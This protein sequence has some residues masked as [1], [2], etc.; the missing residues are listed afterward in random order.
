MFSN[1]SK[2]RMPVGVG[3]HTPLSIPFAGG[4]AADYVMRVAVG[5]QVELNERNLPTGRKLPLSEQFA[6]LREGGLRVTECDPIEAGFTLKEIDV[7]GKVVPRGAGRERAHGCADLLRG[8]FPDDL[9]DDLEQRGPGALRRRPEPQSWT[10]NALESSPQS[11]RPKG[12][13]RIAP[14]ESW[15]MVFPALREI[16]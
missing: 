6:K 8:G 12:S 7:N 14:G 11:L 16:G 5:E 13:G 4:D 1:R 10:T 15:R 9:L 3:F 2:L